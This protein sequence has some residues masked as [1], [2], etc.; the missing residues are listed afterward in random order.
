[1]QQQLKIILENA[2]GEIDQVKDLQSLENVRVRY[3]GK[4][5]QLTD[6]LK[7]LG[8]LPANE[9]PQAGQAINQ[10]KE[11]LQQLLNQQE[12]LLSNAE[13]NN[14]LT[15]E[16]IDVTLSGRGQT[17]GS[18][19]PITRTRER[20]EKLFAQVGFSV[21]EGPEIE[22][23]YHNFEALNIP[24]YHP[25][26]AQHDTFYFGDG[27]LL[28]THTSPVQI[29]VMESAKLPLRV[30]AP[31]RV[32]RCDSDLRHTPMFHQVEG[33]VVDEKANF[34]DLKALLHDFLQQFFETPNLKV[35]FRPA[36]FPFTEPSAEVD[37]QCVICKGAGCRLCS[38]TGWLEILGC[39][40]VHPNVFKAVGIDSER[41]LGYA[42]GMGI[43]RLTMLRY[44]IPDLRMMFE[45]DLRFLNQF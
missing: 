40:M 5:G 14:K 16:S 6:Y 1:M 31:G 35:R 10:V 25:A 12:H 13:L 21:A 3:L 30:I 34:A 37:V 32:Y 27:K 43:D 45:N 41:Y 9:R 20:I 15:Q 36:Y 11:Q 29:R 2:Q 33:L 39:G 7:T 26:R 17:L 28:R 8:Q 24:D 22:D 42:F 18:L 44:S 4:K 23:D 38:K 19:H